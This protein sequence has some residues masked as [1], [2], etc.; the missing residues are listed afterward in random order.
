MN[1]AF[2]LPFYMYKTFISF[3]LLLFFT[4]SRV[5]QPPEA[6]FNPQLW[7]LDVVDYGFVLRANWRV[8]WSSTD[9]DHLDDSLHSERQ[10]QAVKVT[11]MHDEKNKINEPKHE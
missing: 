4:M 5:Q 8:L 9:L 10:I 1:I 2:E 7:Q 3:I 6:N 11:N